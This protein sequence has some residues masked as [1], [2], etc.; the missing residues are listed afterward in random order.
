MSIKATHDIDR[1][2]AISVII[3]KIN[4]CSND[5]IANML[6]E[7]DESYFRNYAVH[8]VLPDVSSEYEMFTIRN[9]N[10]F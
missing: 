7:F 8:D 3:N 4:E 1:A 10:E 9:F 5:Q 2:T 6:E